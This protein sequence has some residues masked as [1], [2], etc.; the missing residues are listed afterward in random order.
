M[1]TSKKSLKI[2]EPATANR[3]VEIDFTEAPKEFLFFN[4]YRVERSGAF[5]LV[6]LVFVDATGAVSPVFRGMIWDMDLKI[7]TKD[8]EGYIE[9]IG[10]PKSDASKDPPLAIAFGSAP[11]TINRIDCAARGGWAEIAIRQFSHKAVIDKKQPDAHTDTISGITHG[12]YVSEVEV[13]KRLIY[14]LI[15]TTATKP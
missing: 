6:S 14:D 1:A 9:R 3:F 11:A 8:L 4:R 5:L 10:A 7:Q 12:V 13:H 2:S 15:V